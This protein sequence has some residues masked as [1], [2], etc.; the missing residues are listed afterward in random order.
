M[1]AGTMK[2]FAFPASMSPGG[3]TVPLG[4]LMGIAGILEVVGGFLMLIGLFSRTTAFILAGEMAVAYFMM[5]APHGF[6]PVLN[7]G[8]PALFF[9][10]IWLFFSAAGP[11]PWALDR[12]LHRSPA[13]TPVMHGKTP[14][15][16]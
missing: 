2:L 16:V 13:R 11:G 4:S 8:E 12:L 14:R 7:Q 5:H 15:M 1:Q 9:C 3:G 6:W 10:F